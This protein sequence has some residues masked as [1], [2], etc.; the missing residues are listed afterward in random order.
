[1]RPLAAGLPIPADH[2][3]ANEP[4]LFSVPLGRGE[5]IHLRGKAFFQLRN[6]AEASYGHRVHCLS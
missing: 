5:C 6:K 3:E 1:M 2:N 4:L